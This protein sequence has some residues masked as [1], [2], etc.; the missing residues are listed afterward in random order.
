MKKLSLFVISLLLMTSCATDEAGITLLPEN[1]FKAEVDGKPT[2]LYTVRSGDLVM[3][4]TDFGARI[5]SLWAPDR[6]GGY[7]DVILGYENIADYLDNQGERYLGAIVGPYANRIAG[8]TY[9]IED[10]VYDFPIN[11]NSNTLHGGVKGLD[12]VVWD[13]VSVEDDSI[14]LSYVHK[15]GQEG[16]PGNLEI[17]VRYTLTPENELKVDYSA[18]TDKAVHVNL[19]QHSYFNLKGEGNGT[20]TD[21]EMV[22]N[23][24]YTTVIDEFLIPTGEIA[25]VE[26]TP[27]DFR[28]PRLIG[29]RINADNNQITNGMG[30]DHNWILDRKGED[31][32]EF[33]VSVYDHASGRLMEV[34]TDQPALQFYSGNFMEGNV[35]GKSGKTLNYREAIVLE[36][37]KYPDTPHHA[38][39]PSTL[40]EPGQEYSHTCVYK[41]GVR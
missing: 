11:D 25:S 7:D 38:H 19:S 5:V 24:S 16:K 22:I 6:N 21:H 9:S 13:V 32:L 41:F 29:E 8:G 36:T 27:F 28:E 2:S 33:A 12:M 17:Q 26:G 1:D 4:V 23:S 30:Y 31:G 3:Q 20:I 18:F 34:F 14:V 39:F 15:D 40:L 10:E 35:K 37:Q